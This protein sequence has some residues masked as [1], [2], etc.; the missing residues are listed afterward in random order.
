MRTPENELVVTTLNNKAFP[1]INYATEDIVQVKD[2]L[3]C[4]SIVALESIQGRKK[5]VV[6]MTK[7]DGSPISMSAIQP[8][9][10]LKG[11]PE[12]IGVQYEQRPDN[13]L[14]VH[15]KLT[16]SNTLERITQ[17]FHRS[18]C[19]DYPSV[20]LGSVSIVETDDIELTTAGKAK[21]F[22]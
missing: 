3:R 21:L 19:R 8:V 13:T 7:M 20:N 2:E 10:I 6:T 4:G 18:L 11:E 9:H 5:D 15:V 17:N 1:L 22:R 12:I 14:V 16:N